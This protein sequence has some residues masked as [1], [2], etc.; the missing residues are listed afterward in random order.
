MDGQACGVFLL[1]ELSTL[2]SSHHLFHEPTSRTRRDRALFHRY[3][4]GQIARFIDIVAFYQR[5][6]VSKQL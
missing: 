2:L 6:M 5:H 3:A 4:F 1:N